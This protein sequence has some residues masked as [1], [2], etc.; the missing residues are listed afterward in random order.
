MGSLCS[1]FKSSKDDEHDD[2]NRG[3]LPSQSEV[4]IDRGSINGEQIFHRESTYDTFPDPVNGRL[5]T[6]AWNRTLEKMAN[7]VIDVSTIDIS[8]ANMEPSELVERQ[9]QYAAKVAASKVNQLLKKQRLKT[10]IASS[11]STLSLSKDTITRLRAAADPIDQDDL[12]LLREFS[13]KTVN[14]YKSGFLISVKDDLVVQFD[15]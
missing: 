3:L 14:A 2:E 11:P 5:D 9:K 10:S 1:C 4:T 6:P 12:T 7:N 15:P 8:S 13:E